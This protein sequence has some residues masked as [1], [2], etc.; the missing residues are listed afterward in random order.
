ML[1]PATRSASDGRGARAR[2]S[3]RSGRDVVV[4]TGGHREEAADLFFDGARFVAIPGP[5]HP[6]GAAHGSGCTHSS[7]LAAQ[8]A[9]GATPLEAAR[10]AREVAAEAVRHGLRELG[11]GRRARWTCSPRRARDRR[12]ARRSALP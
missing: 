2:A 3:T 6:D 8:L 4:V 11:D 5:R 9:L 1:V 10:T 12:C 7:T